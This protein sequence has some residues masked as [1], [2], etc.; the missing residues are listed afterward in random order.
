M[1]EGD[2]HIR[3]KDVRKRSGIEWSP[4]WADDREVM[5]TR[6]VG[7]AMILCRRLNGE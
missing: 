7:G 2:K 3:N 4:T 5:G 1:A 6:V